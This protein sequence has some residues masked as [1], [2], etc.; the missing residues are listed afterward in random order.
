MIYTERMQY[1]E[2]TLIH[3]EDLTLVQSGNIEICY[4]NRDIQACN[5]QT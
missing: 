4:A 3:D 2:Y 1:L 5:S